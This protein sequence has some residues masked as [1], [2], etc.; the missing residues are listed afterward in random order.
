MSSAGLELCPVSSLPAE[1]EAAFP[2]PLPPSLGPQ[3]RTECSACAA[4]EQACLGDH[5][6]STLVVH[7][8]LYHP[9]LVF[10][11]GEKLP[12]GDRIGPQSDR[13]FSPLIFRVLA[14][15]MRGHAD[16]V[17]FSGVHFL[18]L[19]NKLFRVPGHIVRR[20]I[21]LQYLGPRVPRCG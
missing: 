2:R 10:F 16:S 12:G 15:E 7:A 20:K 14:P 11:F 1:A 8:P 4:G 6:L 9:H 3:L 21:A 17:A 13:F 19:D 5:P 18:F